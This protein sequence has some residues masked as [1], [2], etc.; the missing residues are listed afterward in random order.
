M[1]RLALAL[2]LLLVGCEEQLSVGG[3]PAVKLPAAPSE[4]DQIARYV[5]AS[6]EQR[7][8]AIEEFEKSVEPYRKE[9][10]EKTAAAVEKTIQSVIE[11]R[12]K[13]GLPTPDELADPTYN[14]VPAISIEPKV[15]DIGQF[16]GK[17]PGGVV[18]KKIIDGSS[19]L[20]TPFGC[21]RG[22][23][24]EYGAD[25]IVSGV[26]TRGLVDGRDLDAHVFDVIGA[27]KHGDRTLVGVT[28]FDPRK[29]DAEFAK[30][31]KAN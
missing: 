4:A 19:L 5:K 31:A 15:G 1:R 29:A 7:P 9:A 30:R 20:G 2:V 11:G 23:A 24:R 26:S 16:S 28:P 21:E 18:V 6:D 27:A 3:K 10:D 12:K 25:V 13:L 17:R 14:L 22:G 8:A